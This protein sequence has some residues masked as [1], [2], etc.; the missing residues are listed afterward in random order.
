MLIEKNGERAGEKMRRK[1]N[2]GERRGGRQGVARGKIHGRSCTVGVK[3]VTEK[4][5]PVFG[6]RA[7][8]SEHPGCSSHG[9]ERG[10]KGGGG[11]R[12]IEG[13]QIARGG[14]FTIFRVAVF[15]YE[16]LYRHLVKHVGFART[17]DREGED[18]RR[19]GGFNN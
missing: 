8:L 12:T 11:E 2:E 13:R 4:F 18:I 6:F 19:L 5:V 10:M 1:W 3:S 16:A 14:G 9:V 17:F 7:R 15:P